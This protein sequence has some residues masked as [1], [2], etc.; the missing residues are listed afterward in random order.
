MAEEE[1]DK[2]EQKNQTLEALYK[3]KIAELENERNQ[4][5]THLIS[6][7]PQGA[8]LTSAIEVYTAVINDLK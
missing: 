2:P 4:L 7:S 8:R 3:E 6:Q 5:A 1:K